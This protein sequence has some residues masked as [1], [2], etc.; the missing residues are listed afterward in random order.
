MEKR[1]SGILL[2]ITSLP[3]TCGIGDLGPGAYR[4]VD[5]LSE[6][7]QSL[8]QI[9]PLNRT[10]TSYGNSPYSSYSAFAGNPLLI[11][12]DLLIDHGLLLR[13][14]VVPHPPFSNGRVNYS[15]VTSYKERILGRAYEKNKGGLAGNYEF[16]KFCSENTVWLDDYS[17]FMALKGH[18]S[19]GDWSVWP[20]D[21]RDRKKDSLNEWGRRLQEIILMEKFFQ[22][23]FFKQ[24][25][26]LKNYCSSKNIRIIGDMPIYV[27]Y[28]SSDV[29]TNT[30]LFSLGEVK[31]PL[32]VAGVPPDYFSPTGQLWG[33]PVYNWEIL[34]E[35]GYSWWIKR[36]EHNA[37]L[38][39]LFRLDHFRGF[40][41]YWKIRA[42]DKSA[43]NGEWVEAPAEDFF[44][45]LLKHFHHLPII[46]EDLGFITPDVRE[47]MN[48][49][50]FPGMKVLLFAFGKDVSVNPYAP[51]NHIRN[52]V[53]YT[54]THD[55][56]TIR[57]WFKKEL[58]AEDRNRISAYTGHR[59]TGKNIHAELI[60]LAMC[61]V[62]GT[63][64]IPMQDILGLGER[65]R[66]NQPAVARGN[67][68]W[69]L[70]EEQL[71]PLLIQK[72]SEMTRIY[73]RG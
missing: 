10:C 18:F 73:G 58:D 40:V 37:G 27:N 48:Q 28:D 69:R 33:H 8:W 20:E 26:L 14:D 60:R 52:C 7:N 63:V 62:A 15:A 53:V 64:I 56:N 36:F 1:E 68:E 72:L 51:H 43:I 21:L 2:H 65:A 31:K 34:K 50:G 25:N 67:W 13:S 24:W 41:G 30:E 47:I 4:F 38:F 71:S 54:G 19:G 55:N 39:H 17:L 32:F 29:W 12:P 5:F 11:S 9:L 70:A 44:S 59:V 46:A 49:F 35:R 61:S 3:S 6:T 66:M 23:L 42:D 22:Y 45:T 16:Q 57:G